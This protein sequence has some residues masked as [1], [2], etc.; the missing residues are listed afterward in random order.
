MR[1]EDPVHWSPRLKAWVL[2]RYE[3]VKRVCLDGGMSSE[4][5]QPFFATLPSEQAQK[6][7]ALARY[8]VY[9]HYEP[10]NPASG[11]IRITDVFRK[12]D[13]RWLRDD[14]SAPTPEFAAAQARSSS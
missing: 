11:R 2:S 13:G 4:R 5:L 3:D 7:A 12:F 14:A 8:H 1:D 6:L 9:F 10:P